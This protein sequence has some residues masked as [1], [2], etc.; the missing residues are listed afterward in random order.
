MRDQP[1]IVDLGAPARLSDLPRLAA[2]FFAWWGGTLRGM[3]PLASARARAKPGATLYIR[4]DRWFIKTAADQGALTIE[5]A[6]SDGELAD[7]LLL[8]GNRVPLSRLTVALPPEHVL[9]RRLE[10]PLMSDAYLRQAV[11]LQIDRLSPFKTDAVR[12]DARVATRDVERGV[13]HVDAAIV[14]L[15]RIVPVE[16]R[17]RALGIEAVAVDVEG[18]DGALEG[19]DLRPAPTPEERSRR[20]TFNLFLAVAAVAVWILAVVAWNDAG[21]REAE[22]WRA[23]IAELTPAAERSAAVRRR[24]EAMAAPVTAANAHEPTQMLDILAELTRVLPQTARVV[25]LRVGGKEIALSGLAANAP[26]LIAAL[27]S[28]PRFRGVKFASP[29]VRKSDGTAERFDIVMAL[30]EVRAP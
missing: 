5:T 30:E 29:V 14:P 10:L 3:L 21:A 20:R 11:E 1:L 27:E 6:A 8:A 13:A 28:S 7:R 4:R 22:A 18:K 12:Y 17:L 24:I 9:L 16:Q 15:I 2:S 19:F 25:D 23:R 26:A